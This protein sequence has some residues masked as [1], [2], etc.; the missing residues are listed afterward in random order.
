MFVRWQSPRRLFFTLCFLT[1]ELLTKYN[2][3]TPRQERQKIKAN[4]KC[5]E[6]PSFKCDPTNIKQLLLRCNSIL[7]LRIRLFYNRAFQ[8]HTWNFVPRPW[9]SCRGTKAIERLFASFWERTLDTIWR[10]WEWC[11]KHH[12]GQLHPG[13]AGSLQIRHPREMILAQSIRSAESNHASFTDLLSETI[14]LLHDILSTLSSEQFWNRPEKWLKPYFMSPSLKSETKLWSYWCKWITQVCTNRTMQKKK[15]LW[16][17]RWQ[18][19]FA[20]P[21]DIFLSLFDVCDV[22][23]TGCAERVFVL[24]TWIH[25][26]MHTCIHA[27]GFFIYLLTNTCTYKDT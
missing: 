12:L 4:E 24:H 20:E 11:F 18:K 13:K 23:D 3:N 25:T 2:S 21:G 26:Y 22:L 8:V 1:L 16:S 27:Y 5:L 6:R 19:E 7:S 14:R 10:T 9:F 17:L 15:G